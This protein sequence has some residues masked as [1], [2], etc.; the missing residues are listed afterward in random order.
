MYVIIFKLVF[1]LRVRKYQIYIYDIRTNFNFVLDFISVSVSYALTKFLNEYEE[2]NPLWHRCPSC[3]EAFPSPSSLRLHIQ[4][5]C[6]NASTLHAKQV[7]S[8]EARFND[9]RKRESVN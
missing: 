7:Q 5:G 9:F 2:E 8:M 6:I 3:R 4:V 1:H